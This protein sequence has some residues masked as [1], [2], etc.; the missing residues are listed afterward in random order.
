MTSST[1]SSQ[2][3]LDLGLRQL[4]K[5]W[6]SL[7]V[8]KGLTHDLIAGLSVA[9]V[10][11]P[12]CLA[13]ALA[14]GVD[15]AAGIVSSI[16]AG[17]ICALFGGTSLGISGPASALVVILGSA[18]QQFGM[19]GLLLVGIGCGALQL[20]S[21]VLGFGRMI[22]Y[23]PFSV[24]AGFT[25]GVGAIILIGQLPRALGLPPPDQSHVIYVVTHIGEL[26]HQAQLGPL[27][28]AMMTVAITF[29]LPWI[30][31]RIPAP[32]VGV[33]IPTLVAYF[34]G[35]KV[36][37]VG[38]I[39]R[40]LPSPHFPSFNH[41]ELTSLLGTTLIAFCIASVET[42]LSSDTVDR[43]SQGK[44]HQSKSDPNQELIGQGLG[45]I[46]ASLFGGILVTGVIARSAL[47]VK[48]GAKTRRSALF[49]PLIIFATVAVLAPWM[50]LIPTA[51]LAGI[52]L[53]TALRM[54]RPR[55]L[56]QLWSASRGES[57][58]YL[59]TFCSLVFAD[60][61]FS[62]QA[63]VLAAL[64]IA[65]LKL[66]RAGASIEIFESKGPSQI[67]LRGPLTFLSST[68]INAARNRL[69]K[70]DR[71]RGVVVDLSGVKSIDTS[72]ANHLIELLDQLKS[73]NTNYVLK[74]LAP[75]C[76][77]VLLSLDQSHEIANHIASN[78]SDLL[79][80]LEK[81][82]STSGLDRLVYGVEKF[83]RE[84][85]AGYEGLFAKLATGQ[86]PHTLFITCS[87]SRIDPN[88]ITATDPGELFIV[89][90]VGN[91]IPPFGT[92]GAPAEGAAVEFAI[93]VLGV[94]DIVVCGHSGCGAMS[95]LLSGKIFTPESI[96]NLPSVA[97][98][99]EGSRGIKKQLPKD[100]TPE[101]GAEL[102]SLIQLEN[103]KTYPIIIDRLAKGE[104][105][106]HA[107]YYNI[108]AGDLE[109]WDDVQKMFVLVGSKAAKSLE[110]RVE[111]GVQYQAPYVPST[112]TKN[113]GNEENS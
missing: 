37:L 98:W 89:R 84:M 93:G 34:F 20:L 103:L 87:D 60:L 58:V 5:E 61:I 35:M 82:R 38:T 108:G 105:R 104:V 18:V 80:L 26:I 67:N 49:Y 86:S 6:Q 109:E 107:W 92:D 12:L 41:L 75:D 99:L 3:R 39:P 44:H 70:I 19:N 2:F 57:F 54:L 10:A 23:V 88:L 4:F 72:G 91:I 30:T 24:V 47:N 73:Q 48:S 21:G 51:V 28:L 40:S 29:V 68:E 65:G 102:N 78:E 79:T 13:I 96:A 25:A 64:V 66:G 52:M 11:V 83:R 69:E 112:E 22:R 59:V 8:S 14:T 17:L 63:G 55:E 101:Q 42:L 85:L 32:L 46:A 74:G 43:L 31:P 113:P 50:S 62:A 111:A 16:V 56:L 36:E 1:N 94:K 15:P 90:N 53:S 100:A 97:K 71:R 9:C 76:R 33:V 81:D 45:N 95:A 110:R 27:L 77:K 7:L 106:L